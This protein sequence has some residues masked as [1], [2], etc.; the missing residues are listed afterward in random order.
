MHIKKGDLVEVISGNYRGV[1]GE[2]LRA[3]PAEGRVVVRGVN[4]VKKHQRPQQGGR[5]RARGG[6]IEFEAPIDVSNVMIIDPKTNEPT[7]IGYRVEED[8][9]KVR[10]A[11]RSGAAI[12]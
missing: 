6:I 3:I 2:V 8:G 1:R 10:Y 9:R 4:V 11:K 5:A 12:D 7:R